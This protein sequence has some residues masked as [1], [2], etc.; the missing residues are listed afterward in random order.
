MSKP[1]LLFVCTANISRSRTAE[2]LF[3]GS[4]KYEVKSAGFKM[5]D[6]RSGQLVS[7]EL[8]GWADKIFLM[9]EMLDC[10]LTRLNSNFNSDGK[11]VVVLG[12]PDF[13]GRGDEV[14]VK[15]LKARLAYLGISVG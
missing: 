6:E 2:D 13:Y 1:K 8:V 9:D 4:D 10:H 11:E 5:V 14:L 7:Q 3:F 15:I 12:I